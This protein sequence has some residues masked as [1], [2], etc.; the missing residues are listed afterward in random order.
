MIFL[1]F[2]VIEDEIKK[3]ISRSLEV[4]GGQ[5]RE[6]RSADWPVW[7]QAPLLQA[8]DLQLPSQRPSFMFFS[9]TAYDDN[10]LTSVPEALSITAQIMFV[11]QSSRW[12]ALTTRNPAASSAFIYSV[13]TTRIYCRPTCP[14]RLARR[15]NIVFHDT[16]ADAERDGF[17]PCLRCRPA[18]STDESDTQKIAMKKACAM[19]DAEERGGGEKWGSKALAKEVGLT[20][21]H[22]CRVFKKVTGYTVGEYRKRLRERELQVLRVDDAGM[23]N[24]VMEELDLN[25]QNSVEVPVET[26]RVPPELATGW[27]DFEHSFNPFEEFESFDFGSVLEG[28][29]Y[30]GSNDP[31]AAI[32]AY[33]GMEFVNFDACLG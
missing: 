8:D 6:A 5:M 29:P 12:S 2:K 26:S 30:G 18:H 19:L 25:A 16:V 10:A 3:I 4:K 20:E 1:N 21:S 9:A 17:R 33:D 22:F 11:T 24:G 14:S 7:E 31:G 23:T 32:L 28:A 15:A 13:T 27:D